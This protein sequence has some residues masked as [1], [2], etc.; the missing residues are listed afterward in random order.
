M[1][2]AP[3]RRWNI[4]RDLTAAGLVCVALLFPW[5]L[6]FGVGV[7]A[8]RP[9]LFAVL[10][11]ATVLSL[12]SIAATYAGR[13]RVF[14]AQF[15]PRRKAR[16]RLVLNVPYLVLVCGFVVFDAVQ[17]I[18][19][20]GS[21]R[22]PGGVGPGAW[23]GVAGALLAAQPVIAGGDDTRNWPSATRWLGYVSIAGAGFG[24]LFNLYWRIR[25]ALP[26]TG[27]AGG[28]GGQHVAIITTAVVYGAVAWAAV[29]VASRWLLRQEKPSQIASVMLGGSAVVSGALVWILP[30]GRDIDGFHGIAQNTSTAGVGFEGYLVWAAAA[31]ILAVP[32][33]HSGLERG[34]WLGA[35]RKMLLLIVVW[36]LASALMR[37][38]D[39]AVATRLD[40]PYSPYDSAAMA[41]FDVVTAV[42]AAWLRIN[43]AGRSLPPAVNWSMFAVLCGFTIA[44]IVVGIGLA[45]RLANSHRGPSTAGAVYGNDLAQQITSTFDV[46]LCGLALCGFAIAMVTARDRRPTASAVAPAESPRIFRPDNNAP[47]NMSD[48]TPK[49]FRPEDD[50]AAHG[51]HER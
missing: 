22:P 43:L 34:V 12:G 23:L 6:Y 27:D 51:R 16:V 26:R 11:V 32:V 21:S 44:R 41:A 10:S 19:Y 46:V 31:A 2:S 28:F 36:C 35:A 48:N 15:D 24:V 45:P 29:A 13:R 37:G 18:R 4:G 3:P 25:Y 14:G 38:T 17:T 5:N 33:L 30:L 47:P 20:G 40:L 39:L 7:P 9:V 50:S 1:L 8:S 49:I 42:I